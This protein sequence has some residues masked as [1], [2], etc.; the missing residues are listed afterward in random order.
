LPVATFPRHKPLQRETL[1]DSRPRTDLSVRLARI[2]SET[3]PVSHELIYTN[4]ARGFALCTMRSTHRS[5]YY[6]QCSLDDHIDQMA[7]DRFWDEFEAAV[8][9]AAGRQLITG[10]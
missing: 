3:P 2:L 4:H 10:P 8:D 6:V 1:G 5:R 7:D 9:Q